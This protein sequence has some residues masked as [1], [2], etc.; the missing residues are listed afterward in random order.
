V[1]WNAD[2]Q[3]DSLY[4]LVLED[5][6]T[7]TRGD[8][9]TLDLL[10]T[11]EFRN[12]GPGEVPELDVYIAVPGDLP[13]QTLLSPVRF[14][15]EPLEILHDRWRQPVAHFHFENPPLAERLQIRMETTAELS[16][17]RRLIYPHEVG[18]LDDIPADVR[19]TYLVDEDKY[20]IH[21]PLIEKAAK[22][23]VG[24]ET[25]PYW[26]MRNIHKYIRERLHY[27]LAGGWNVAPRVLA[28]GSG[29]CSEYTF[30]FISL[31]RAAGIPARYVGAVVV[32]GD[33]ASTDQ[34]FHRWSQVYLPG[35]GWVNVDP[36]GGDKEKPA[37]VAASIGTVSN[38]VLITTQGGGASEYLKWGYNY[39][40]TWTAKGPVKI[41]AEALGEWSPAKVTEA[42]SDA[43]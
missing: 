34:Y 25:N 29:S 18:T 43:P 42:V 13:N 24:E 20:R 28:R 14:T 16:T 3:S 36:Q 5:G 11:Y 38:R 7:T 22:E 33:E 2:Y 40:Q 10:L 31:C 21:D 30:L 9:H 27:E 6:E 17:A 12:Y 41:H 26:M 1:L 23:A 15:P 8:E 39:E 35:Y 19:K 4:A 32:R 37:D